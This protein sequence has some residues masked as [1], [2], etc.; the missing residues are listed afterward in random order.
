MRMYVKGSYLF[1]ETM[2]AVISHTPWQTIVLLLHKVPNYVSISP[3]GRWPFPL[4]APTK[5]LYLQRP[6]PLGLDF[7]CLEHYLN[8]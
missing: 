5:S 7:V 1:I 2:V 4:G 3:N 6:M 8:W